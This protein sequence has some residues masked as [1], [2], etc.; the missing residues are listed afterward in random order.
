MANMVC[1]VTCIIVIIMPR[2]AIKIQ[3]IL[4]RLLLVNLLKE[5]KEERYNIERPGSIT[6]ITPLSSENP[7]SGPKYVVAGCV[8]M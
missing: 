3:I 7:S 4:L 8:K 1:L 5:I 6:L 2:N